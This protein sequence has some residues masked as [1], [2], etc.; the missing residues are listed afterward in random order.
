MPNHNSAIMDD[1]QVSERKSRA[2]ARAKV[3]RLKGEEE[4][5]DTMKKTEEKHKEKK[6]R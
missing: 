2:P 5:E 6:R 3:D 4:F 1:V